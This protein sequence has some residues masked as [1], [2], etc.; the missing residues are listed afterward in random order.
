MTISALYTSGNAV[1]YLGQMVVTGNASIGKFRFLKDHFIN[2]QFVPAGTIRTMF[3]IDNWTVTPDVEPLD[4][5]A[6]NSFYDQGPQLGGVINNQWTLFNVP[7]PK[8]YW[9]QSSPFFWALSGLGADQT[10]YPPI[11]MRLGRVE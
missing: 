8:T 9:F 10:A 5:P 7:F 3:Q 1:Y 11:F 6:T 4:L 2:N